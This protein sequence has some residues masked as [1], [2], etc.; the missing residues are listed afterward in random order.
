MRPRL[1]AAIV[2]LVVFGLVAGLIW[3]GIGSRNR[4]VGR[5]S[6]GTYPAIGSRYPTELLVNADGSYVQGG[7][8]GRWHLD[9]NTLV[10]SPVRGGSESR[11]APT[12]DGGLSDGLTDSLM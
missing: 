12:V 5:W 3:H 10:L 7:K 1:I 6:G 4:F 11:L 8:V 2:L 9:G